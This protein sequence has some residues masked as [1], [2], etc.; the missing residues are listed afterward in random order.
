[1]QKS[2]ALLAGLVLLF[3]APAWANVDRD[4][5]ASIAQRTSGGRVLSVERAEHD[6]R[7]VWRVKVVTPQGEVRVIYIDAASGRTL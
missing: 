5:A 1:M 4:D 3:A 2:L 6:G 7:Q